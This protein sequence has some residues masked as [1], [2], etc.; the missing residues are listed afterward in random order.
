MNIGQSDPRKEITELTGRWITAL[1][2]RGLRAEHVLPGARG[3][4]ENAANAGTL[5]CPFSLGCCEDGPR[6]GLVT[7][8]VGIPS[9]PE[10]VR[11]EQQLA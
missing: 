10:L 3:R 7:N 5:S 8:G 4:C 9:H 1:E 6:A 2:M 11:R